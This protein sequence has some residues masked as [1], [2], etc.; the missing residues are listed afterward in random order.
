MRFQIAEQGGP[1]MR[2][3][4]STI[5]VGLTTEELNELVEVLEQV[6]QE[7]AGQLAKS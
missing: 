4:T 5:R 7:L 6:V 3:M 1:S 2:P